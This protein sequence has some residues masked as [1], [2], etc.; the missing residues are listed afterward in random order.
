MPWVVNDV[1]RHIKGLSPKQK[2]VWV[3]IANA[4]LSSCLAGG[5]SNESCE[6]SAIRI[7]SSQAKTVKEGDINIIVNIDG[8]KLKIDTK[9]DKWD[10]TD[11]DSHVSNM[12]FDQK[13]AWVKIAN[14]SYD[15]CRLAGGDN[16]Y[17]EGYAVKTANMNMLTESKKEEDMEWTKDYIDKLPNKSFGFVERDTK[18]NILGRHFPFSDIKGKIDAQRLKEVTKEAIASP[19]AVQA[20][21]KLQQAAKI[22][23][24]DEYADDYKGGEGQFQTHFKMTEFREAFGD[25]PKYKPN[26][27]KREIVLPMLKEG[28]GNPLDKNYY[29]A[30]AVVE[31][32]SYLRSRTKMYVN[33]PKA[34]NDERDMRDWGASIKETWVDTLPDGKLISVGRVNV[35]DDWL[36]ERSKAAPDEIGT[37]VLGRGKAKKSMIDGRDANVIESIEYIKSCDFVDYP[38]NTPMGMLYFKESEKFGEHKTEHKIKNI[39]EDDSMKMEDITIGMVKE[40]RPE[41]VAQIEQTVVTEKGKQITDLETKIKEQDKAVTD[42]KMKV[43]NYEVKEKDDA[44]K[45][46][47]E[48]MLQESK[49]PDKAKTPLFKET[50]MKCEDTKVVEDGKEK[51]ITEKDQILALIKDRE[52]MLGIENPI[53]GMGPED[54]KKDITEKD[55]ADFNEGIFGIEPEKKNEKKDE[56]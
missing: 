26:D 19:Y 34:E 16:I 52:V 29:T 7:A 4:T 9:I 25:K 44:K 18:G 30:K 46:I 13:K 48:K 17:C 8:K 21:A 47:V 5:K 32:A 2:T 15:S 36:W 10:M 35:L 31:S 51:V 45:A 56:K 33:H 42:L 39:Q 28:W 20:I 49:I 41:L 37:S 3:K 14:E 38:G 24:I 53:K 40:Q 23:K 55:Q 54:T 27:E 43:D 6:A 22:M 11:A 1:D 50:L 12:N